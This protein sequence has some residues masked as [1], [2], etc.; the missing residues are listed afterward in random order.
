MFCRSDADLSALDRTRES[1]THSSAGERSLHTGEVQG[2]IPCASTSPLQFCSTPFAPGGRST[3]TLAAREAA[4]QGQNKSPPRDLA[5]R[6][7]APSDS[8]NISRS[9]R[10]E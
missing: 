2:S 7:S 1:R 6:A 5:H 3:T 9:K 10:R 8:L 4:N